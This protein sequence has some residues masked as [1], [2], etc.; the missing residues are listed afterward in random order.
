MRDDVPDVCVAQANTPLS[1]GSISLVTPNPRESAT[2]DLPCYKM[3][4]ATVNMMK[5]EILGR[6]NPSMMTLADCQAA[7]AF[8]E[9]PQFW[10]VDYAMFVYVEG[11]GM[12][13]TAFHVRGADLG[14]GLRSRIALPNKILVAPG[15]HSM[16]VEEGIYQRARDL[17]HEIGHH[18]FGSGET[19][20]LRAEQCLNRS[21]GQEHSGDE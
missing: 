10:D 6:L 9:S 8:L 14:P 21:D 13:G 3:S 1:P 16:G 4:N 19:N 2:A 18:I 11:T 5:L 12:T 20:A 7:K 17:L 15:T